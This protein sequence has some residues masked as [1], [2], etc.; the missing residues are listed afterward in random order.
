MFTRDAIRTSMKWEGGGALGVLKTDELRQGEEGVEKSAFGR[1]SLMDD[2]RY[3]RL[4][5]L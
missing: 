5:L 3:S 1:T 2:P 4:D